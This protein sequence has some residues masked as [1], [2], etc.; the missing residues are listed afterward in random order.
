MTRLGVLANAKSWRGVE[1]LVGAPGVVAE[2]PDGIDGYGPAIAR[3]K[4]NGV[5]VIA[6]AGG[7]GTLREALTALI[8]AYD[9]APPPIAFVPRGKTN[10]A[11]ADVG[12]VKDLAA[13][14]A[15]VAAGAPARRL[16][17]RRPMRV[18]AGGVTRYGF[19]FGCGAFERGVRLANAQVHK[20]GFAQ[21][22]GLAMAVASSISAAFS[23]AERQA[24][25]SGVA[26]SVAVDGRPALK[27]DRFVLLATSLHKLMLGLWP[28]WGEGEGEIRLLDV[29]APPRRLARALLA[30]ARRRPAPW[31]AEA[32][33]VSLRADRLELELAAPFILD[34]DTFLADPDGRIELASGPAVTFVTY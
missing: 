11:A 22:I 7:D 8:A 26:A 33:Y 9:G 2:T 15:A 30:V 18:T 1:G 4:A 5:G 10:V 32:G 16:E 34:G 20:R 3:L 23:G 21:G 12:G 14:A 17:I 25:R 31:M 6:I 29:A 27:Q 24:W 13:L 28:F 19:V